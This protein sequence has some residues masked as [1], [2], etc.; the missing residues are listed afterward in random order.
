MAAGNFREYG[1]EN[2][3]LYSCL[4]IR[5]RFQIGV[6]LNQSFAHCILRLL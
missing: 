5:Y 1:E 3:L 6:L 2:A 4:Y